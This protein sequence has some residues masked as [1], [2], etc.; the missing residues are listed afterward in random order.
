M[1]ICLQNKFRYLLISKS[2][3]AFR[4]IM[5]VSF[6]VCS[7]YQ[8][9]TFI[10]LEWLVYV[11]S[12]IWIRC[13]QGGWGLGSWRWRCAVREETLQMKVSFHVASWACGELLLGFCFTNCS[14][15]MRMNVICSPDVSGYLQLHEITI[16][17]PIISVKLLFLGVCT[18]SWLLL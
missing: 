6:N 7:S 17:E 18:I 14:S 9:T 15:T 3:S 1:A 8:T 11:G 5:I 4:S 10:Y 2:S 12:N 16:Q 13:S